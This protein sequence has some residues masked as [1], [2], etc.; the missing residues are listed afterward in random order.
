MALVFP[1]WSECPICG[2]VIAEGEEYVAT[3]AFLDDPDDPLWDYSDAGMHRPCF[4]G[5]E[6]K[7]E[8]VRRFN[9]AMRDLG[10]EKRLF[11]DGTILDMDPRA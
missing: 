7:P 2:K 11:A 9:H 8:F 5:W 4:V 10:F 1:G 3:F 6:K